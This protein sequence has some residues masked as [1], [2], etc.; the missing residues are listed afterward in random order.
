QR[1]LDRGDALS[2]FLRHEASGVF[3]VPGGAAEGAG[4]APA[5]RLSGHDEGPDLDEIRALVF[6]SGD[7]I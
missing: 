4:G 1:K 3:A 2:P 6:S 7:R 5:L